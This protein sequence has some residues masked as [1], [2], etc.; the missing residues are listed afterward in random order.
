M[1]WI[2]LIPVAAV[3]LYG[4]LYDWRIFAAVAFVY[5]GIMAALRLTDWM[6]RRQKK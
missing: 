3:A 5:L 4:L 2:Y 1:S 6:G